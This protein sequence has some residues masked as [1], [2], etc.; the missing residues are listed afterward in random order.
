VQTSS[1]LAAEAAAEA[2]V[3]AEELVRQQEATLAAFNL[4]NS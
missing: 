1:N 3:V 4:P 2:A